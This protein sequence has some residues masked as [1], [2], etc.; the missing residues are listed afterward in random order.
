MLQPSCSYLSK[1]AGWRIG[2]SENFFCFLKVSNL[3]KN[4]DQTT[5]EWCKTWVFRKNKERE[6]SHS[7]IT[8]FVQFSTAVINGDRNRHLSS[9]LQLVCKILRHC[10]D[11]STTSN[12]FLVNDFLK[13]VLL[14]AQASFS[15]LSGKQA[16]HHISSHKH[17]DEITL[18]KLLV[19]DTNVQPWPS[20]LEPA[21]P[22]L[23]LQKPG[24]IKNQYDQKQTNAFL[25]WRQS[26]SISQVFLHPGP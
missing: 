21:I 23:I 12:L 15:E 24:P 6:R 9:Q 20:T 19:K 3:N 1:L 11:Q 2:S 10:S 8:L 26:C 22:L 4:Y 14:F 25:I 17:G 18:I 5:R 7:W 16:Q 13:K